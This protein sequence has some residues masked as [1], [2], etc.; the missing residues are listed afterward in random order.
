MISIKTEYKLSQHAFE[1]FKQRVGKGKTKDAALNWAVQAIQN[2]TNLGETNGY[3][4]YKYGEFK[5][6]VGDKNQI[7]TISYFNDSHIK[8]F[9]KEINKTIRTKFINKLKP[10]YRMKKNLQ[11]ELYE[12]KIRQLKANNP[13]VKAV[14]EDEV[15]NL[16]KELVRTIGSI[17]NIIKAAEH[18]NVPSNELIK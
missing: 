13:K 4:F 17:D 14:I 8:D 12:A 15:V 7:V 11:I 18:Y 5:I 9:K 1:R 2:S 3:R 10:Y 16:E 6:V